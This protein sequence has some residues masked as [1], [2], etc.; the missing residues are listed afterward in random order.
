MV[1]TVTLFDLQSLLAF[2]ALRSPTCRSV[3]QETI[4]EWHEVFRIEPS[5]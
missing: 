4:E 1:E 2:A 5:S 3:H